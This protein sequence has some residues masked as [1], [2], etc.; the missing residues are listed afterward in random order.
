MIIKRTILHVA[1]KP[2][3]TTDDDSVPPEA[4]VHP[5]LVDFVG[6][7]A[8]AAMR[9]K[10]FAEHHGFKALFV[11]KK[12]FEQRLNEGC[13]KCPGRYWEEDARL[14][15]SKC[16]HPQCGCTRLKLWLRSEKCPMNVWE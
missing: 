12:E 10:A 14:G 7:F 9:A 5:T 13:R 1:K 8:E 15:L 2:H 16:S 6:N 11:S 3:R 4:L